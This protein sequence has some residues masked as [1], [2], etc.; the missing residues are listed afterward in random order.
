VSSKTVFMGIKWTT[1]VKQLTN[2]Y[3]RHL[4]NTFQYF[5]K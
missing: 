1:K 4:K 5:F 2:N 3:V